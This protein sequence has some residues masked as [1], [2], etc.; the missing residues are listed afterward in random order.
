M[1]NTIES[2]LDPIRGQVRAISAMLPVG[3]KYYTVNAKDIDQAFAKKQ[4]Q[5]QADPRSPEM[6]LNRSPRVI[7]VRD[8]SVIEQTFK[9]DV[10]GTKMVVFNPNTD[11]EANAT[12]VAGDMN[13]FQTTDEAFTSALNGQRPIFANGVKTATRANV[14]NQSELDRLVEVRKTIDGY[15]D[16]LK[17]AIA[18]NTK[19]VKDYE[20]S[21]LKFKQPVDL[22]ASGPVHVVV[23][24]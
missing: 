4:A 11:D 14:L 19:K 12:I 21:I 10:D 18:S 9:T 24:E 6:I 13:V 1:N 15:I 8:H 20:E 3:S 5:I 16:S 23:T 7:I 17:S 22:G 2:A